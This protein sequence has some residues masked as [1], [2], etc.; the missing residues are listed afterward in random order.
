M[1]KGTRI[2][3]EDIIGYL[4]VGETPETIANDVLPF[5]SLAQIFDALSYYHAYPDEIDRLLT[6][7]VQGQSYAYLQQHLGASDY[8][9][10]TGQAH[11]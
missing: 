3:V 1:I 2:G 6:E 9:Q 4:R 7:D 8:L 11:E 10:I 5:L